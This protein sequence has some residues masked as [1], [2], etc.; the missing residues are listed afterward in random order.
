M[1]V[2]PGPLPAL[3]EDPHIKFIGEIMTIRKS[4]IA[5]EITKLGLSRK[6]S[7]DLIESL[8]AIIKKSLSAGDD[9]LISGFGKFSV[10][11]KRER[12]GRNPATGTSIILSERKV[13][14]FRCSSLLR[15]NIDKGAID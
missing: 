9:V 14:S 13:I 10:R 12:K 6:K 2:R 7:T 3:P 5:E 4:D 11:K 8:L 1:S 15:D